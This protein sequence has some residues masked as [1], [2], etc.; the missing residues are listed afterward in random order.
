MPFKANGA[1]SIIYDLVGTIYACIKGDVVL[2]LGP[3]AGI[4][5]PFIKFI[6][7]NTKII[8]NMA[9][10]E[11][12]REKWGPFAKKIIKANEKY[13]LKSSDIFI[14]DNNGL[15]EYIKKNY[16][17]PSVQIEYGGDQILDFKFKPFFLKNTNL[18]KNKF[19]IAIAR[20]Q[21]DN[22]IEM[23][24]DA[25]LNTDFTIVFISNWQSN[26]YGRKILEKYNKYKNI[27]LIGPF[28]DNDDLQTLRSSARFYIHGHS[29]GGTNPT[30]VEA[31]W[32][33]LPIFAFD[34]IFNRSTLKENGNFFS[35]SRDLLELLVK[36]RHIS[37]NEQI[38]ANLVTA[39]K[40]YS[41]KKIVEA[42]EDLY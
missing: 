26:N 20:A 33:K 15:T 25:Y 31:M 21:K 1:S 40:N 27:K 17:L 28:Y 39:K 24:L 7:K 11:W 29:A 4:F 23:I 32:S 37:L 19:D 5:L 35:N 16:N 36:F 41:W 13:A 8:T 9:G 18:E 38:E 6:F 10:L 3:S 34:N 22:N 2:I 42:Y 12:Q 30:L 14:A